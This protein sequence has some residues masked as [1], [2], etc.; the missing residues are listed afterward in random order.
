M[1]DIL[2]LVAAILASQNGG[3]LVKIDFSRINNF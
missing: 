2:V 1:N 3:S